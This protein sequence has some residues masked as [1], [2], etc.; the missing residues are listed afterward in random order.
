MMIKNT[1]PTYE[2]PKERDILLK[3]QYHMLQKRFYEEKR[4][5]EEKRRAEQKVGRGE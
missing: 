1:I 2:N 4:N 5:A 3:K